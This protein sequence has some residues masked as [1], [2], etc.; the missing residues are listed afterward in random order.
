MRVSTGYEWIQSQVCALS[1]NPPEY[2]QCPT[3][4]TYLPLSID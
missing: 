1:D 3:G 4:Y 2:M